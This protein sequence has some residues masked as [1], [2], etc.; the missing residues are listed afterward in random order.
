MDIRRQISDVYAYE[1]LNDELSFRE[2]LDLAEDPIEVG[3]FQ[4]FEKWI[5]IYEEE[6]Y[7]FT[8]KQGYMFFLK[9]DTPQVVSLLDLA[10][11]QTN[12]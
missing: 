1:F 2:K 5:N 12:A 8:A 4:T 9:E 3:A 7:L 11:D 6:Y 10:H